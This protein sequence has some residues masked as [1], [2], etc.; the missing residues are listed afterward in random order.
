VIDDVARITL[1]TG[2]P[3]ALAHPATAGGSRSAATPGPRPE[4]YRMGLVVLPDIMGLRPLF[5]GHV[6]GLADQLGGPVC[7]IEPWPGRESLT[8]DER[9]AAVGTLV[10]AEVLADAAAAADVTGAAQVG[11]LGFCMGGM[12][13][14]KAASTGRFHRAVS[15]YGMI[16]VPD[17][18]A[19]PAQA[20]PLDL[21]AGG[22]CPVL[23]IIGSADVWTPPDD[24]EALRAA[25]AEV[26]VYEGAEHGFAH[27]PER[28][29]H[30][31]DDAADA[32]RRTR[33]FLNG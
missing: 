2:T 28:P 29:A 23:A 27:D 16:R 20:Q 11:V 12:Y 22:H 24:V 5:D 8:L 25:G 14:L 10:D 4:V 13:A 18:W 7:A 1:S 19:S 17:M 26:V 3:A 30:R 6:Q 33:D 15:F 32:W 31:A 9:L 21:L